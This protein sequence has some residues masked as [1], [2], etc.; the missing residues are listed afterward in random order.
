MGTATNHPVDA[1]GAAGAT[2]NL[3]CKSRSCL[4]S[5]VLG[6]SVIRQVPFAV[7]GNENPNGI[8]AFSL[9][10]TAQRS[11]LGQFRSCPSTLKGLH[12][13]PSD[14]IQPRWG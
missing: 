4:S 2:F 12:P 7:F 5:T 10:L 6:E 9:G 14:V 13:S 11:T 3:K 1:A 8:P